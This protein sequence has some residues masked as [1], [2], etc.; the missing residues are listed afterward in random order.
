MAGIQRG[1]INTGSFGVTGGSGYPGDAATGHGMRNFVKWVD[2]LAEQK[3][4]F[5][6]SLDKLAAVDGRKLE[7]GVKARLPHKVTLGAAMNNSQTTMTLATGHGARVQQGQ[8]IWIPVDVTGNAEEFIWVDSAP[9]ADSLPLVTRGFAGSTAVAHDNSTILDLLAP[10]MPENSDHPLSPVVFGDLFYNYVQRVPQKIQVDKRA[11]VTPNLEMP[12]ANIFES[13]LQDKAEMAKKW[14]EKTFLLGQRSAEVYDPSAKKPSTTAGLRQFSKLSGNTY[15]LSNQL[16]NFYD[17]E[18]VFFD[19]WQNVDDEAGHDVA[20]NLK[21][22]RLL[23]TTINARRIADMDTTEL[24]LRITKVRFDTGVVNIHVFNDMPDGEMYIYN[25]EYLGYAPVKGLDWHVARQK[26]GV[27]TDGDYDE[28]SVS[29][30]FGFYAFAPSTMAYV[31]GFV[32]D[33][34]RYPIDL[35][36]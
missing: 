6:S 29:G 11:D 34:A 27:E 26:A 10:A 31:H 18:E 21:T 7:W 5:L 14:L 24:D 20:M 3:T 15:N 25:P 4:P 32:T 16:L 13:R 36:A 35:A 12:N 9:S 2:A 1:G 22:K 8:M 30:D 33:S 23:S 19:L 28:G 17:I